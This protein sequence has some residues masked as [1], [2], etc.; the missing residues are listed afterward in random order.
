M[1]V[2]VLEIDPAS[3]IVVINF[4][5]PLLMRVCPVSEAS[6]LNTAKDLVKFLFADQ[7]GIVL[8]R[9]LLLGHLH[10]IQG[11]LVIGFDAEKRP[12]FNGRFEAQNLRQKLS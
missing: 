1:P 12:I 3:T 9:D 8:W 6:G 10:K 5:W 4:T 2:Q 7:K 11:D